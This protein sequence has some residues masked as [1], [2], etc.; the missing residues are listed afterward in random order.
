MRTRK[1]A[2]PK[3]KRMGGS[4]GW[5][6]RFSYQRGIFPALVIHVSSLCFFLISKHHPNYFSF[7]F[8]FTFIG[9]IA[10]LKII[11]IL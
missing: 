1:L 7:F 10:W 9:D 6:G 3:E 2:L 4:E 5:G 11:K 8:F